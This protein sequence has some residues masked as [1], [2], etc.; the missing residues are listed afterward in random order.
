ISLSTFF[1]GDN[2]YSPDHS[3][4]EYDIKW[5]NSTISLNWANMLPESRISNMSLSYVNY[6]FK[7]ILNDTTGNASASDYYSSSSLQDII[8]KKDY[9]L[10]LAENNLFK[11]GIDLTLHNY[12][13]SFSNVYSPLLETASGNDKA[14]TSFEG[15]V[16]IQSEWQIMDLLKLNPGL[17]IYYF[18]E[19]NNIQIEPRLAV[20]YNLT[21]DIAFKAA[22]AKAHQFFHLIIKNDISLPT[23]LWYPSSGTI[24]PGSSEQ[25]VLAYDQSFSDKLYNFSI[26]GYYKNMQNLY[27]FKDNPVYNPQNSIIDLFTKGSGEAYGIE[28][29][30]NKSSGKISGWLG[31]TLSWTRRKFDELNRGQIFYPRFDR[32][33]DVSLV[34]AYRFTDNLRFGLTWTYATGQGFTLPAGQYRIGG[35]DADPADRIQFDYTERNAYKL[36]D[37]HK[38]DLN[39]SYEFTWSKYQMEAYININ[40]VYNRSNPFAY[41]A[42]I[43]KG[44]ADSGA[45]PL[46]QFHSISLFPFIPSIGINIRY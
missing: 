42:S 36:P 32:R 11:F 22:Y 20:T 10:Y 33:H 19:Q 12:K 18:N 27:E 26:E 40:N 46:P 1:S 41:Y 8:L 39:A 15:A 37:Y 4:I 28:F 43:D 45:G 2:I 35:V 30:L 17:R 23:D 7:S 24:E 3:S 34:L 44:P 21:D 29:F 5:N 25:Y 9:E 31:Y 6:K 13:L 16:F 14:L 38:L